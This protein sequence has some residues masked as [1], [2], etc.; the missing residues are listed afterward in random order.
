MTRLRTRLR[1]GMRST[2][3]TFLLILV[4]GCLMSEVRIRHCLV[5]NGRSAKFFGDAYDSDARILVELMGSP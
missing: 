3:A 5:K 4:I 2:N 1:R